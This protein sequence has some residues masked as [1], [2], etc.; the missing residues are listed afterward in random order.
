MNK[1]GRPRLYATDAERQTA[2]RARKRA[3]LLDQIPVVHGECYSL[4]CGDAVT[5]VPLLSGY[6]HCITDPPYEAQAHTAT[7]RT[8]AV[9]EGRTPYAE[10]DFAPITPT[11]RRLFGTLRCR[12]VLA[13]CQVEAVG[14]YETLFGRTKYK[15]A[16]TWVKHDSAPQFT[17]DRPAQGTES[18]AC[19]WLAPG[20]SAWNGGGKRGVYHYGIRDGESRLHPTQKPIGLMRELVRDFT[21]PGDVVLDPFMGSATT[22]KACLLEGRRFIGIEHDAGYFYSACQRLEAT[23]R[24]GQLFAVPGRVQQRAL[25]AL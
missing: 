4:Y 17:G 22:G 23:A 25:L 12:W 14:T 16:C 7:R 6:D 1:V 8:R 13:F 20:R 3:A 15:R 19:A 24:Q 18:I 11:Q 5:L 9:L 21:Q 10:I 2:C